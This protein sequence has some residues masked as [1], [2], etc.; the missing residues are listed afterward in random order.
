MI[1]FPRPSLR[2]RLSVRPGARSCSRRSIISRRVFGRCVRLPS[3]PPCGTK[4]CAKQRAGGAVRNTGT[5]E[6]MTYV[7]NAHWNL[8]MDLST[9]AGDVL[10]EG[11]EAKAR[12]GVCVAAGEFYR[13]QRHVL[14]VAMAEELSGLVRRHTGGFSIFDQGPALHYAY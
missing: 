7:R 14:F 9:V 6:P 3:I 4:A 13:D 12:T 5:R 11:L 8:R 1:R 10:P 2:S